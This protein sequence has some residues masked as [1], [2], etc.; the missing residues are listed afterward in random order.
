M[1]YPFPEEWGFEYAKIMV[2]LRF[3]VYYAIPLVIIGVFYALIARHLMYAANVPG[4]MHGAVRQVSKIKLF[5]CC[6]CWAQWIEK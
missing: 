6:V 4:E 3:L 5:T 1:C 2:L